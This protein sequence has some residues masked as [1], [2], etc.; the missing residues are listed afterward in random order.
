MACVR[1]ITSPSGSRV[2]VV[3]WY[4]IPSSMLEV[5]LYAHDFAH[6]IDGDPDLEQLGQSPEWFNCWIRERDYFAK[7][8]FDEQRRRRIRERR[9]ESF[10]TALAL[11]LIKE[12]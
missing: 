10:A 3:I 5:Y 8:I 2:A 9:S 11:G 6:V 7:R 4:D 1:W 12:D